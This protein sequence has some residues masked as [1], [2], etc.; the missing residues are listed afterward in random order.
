MQEQEETIAQI[1]KFASGG[2][3]KDKVLCFRTQTEVA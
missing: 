3:N 1:S 2:T